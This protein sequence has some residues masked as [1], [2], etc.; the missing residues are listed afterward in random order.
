MATNPRLTVLCV[1]P[2]MSS[3]PS[4]VSFGLSPSYGLHTAHEAHEWFLEMMHEHEEFV[5]HFVACFL[6]V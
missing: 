5:P 3:P 1:Y 2:D 6:R 4:E